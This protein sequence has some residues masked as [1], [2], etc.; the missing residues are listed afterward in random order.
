[1]PQTWK[2]LSTGLLC[3]L[4]LDQ[5]TISFIL[6]SRIWPYFTKY[7]MFTFRILLLVVIIF[8]YCVSKHCQKLRKRCNPT[9]N[10]RIACG[11]NNQTRITTRERIQ[12]REGMLNKSKQFLNE[13]VLNQS[14]LQHGI[15]ERF[16]CL[17]NVILYSLKSIGFTKQLYKKKWKA[18]SITKLQPTLII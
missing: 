7:M 11:I 4:L 8:F 14:T 2:M 1:M 5:I 13:I 12:I 18:Y 9:R 3:Y 16:S 17:L 10:Q 6:V 15:R